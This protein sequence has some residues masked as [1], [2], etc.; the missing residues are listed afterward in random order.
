[1]QTMFLVVW[2]VEIIKQKNKMDRRFFCLKDYVEECLT[3][4]DISDSTYRVKTVGKGHREVYLYLFGMTCAEFIAQ[5]GNKLTNKYCDIYF[6][7]GQFDCSPM[8][9]SVRKK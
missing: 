2:G 1:M 4:N 8:Y 7:Q 9:V 5:Y 6:A 3:D